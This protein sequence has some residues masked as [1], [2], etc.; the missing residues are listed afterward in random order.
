[1]R[2]QPSGLRVELDEAEALERPVELE[3]VPEDEGRRAGAGD[4]GVLPR[5]VVPGGERVVL[6]PQRGLADLRAD[7]LDGLGLHGVA[8]RVRQVERVH[9]LAAG[10]RDLGAPDG[11]PVLPEDASD[12]REQ[13]RAV[14]RPHLQLQALGG[15]PLDGSLQAPHQPLP[16]GLAPDGV[17]VDV[18]DVVL[19]VRAAAGLRADG[20]VVHHVLHVRDG[21]HGVEQQLGPVAAPDHHGRV[22]ALGARR[23]G[24]LRPRRA[25]GVGVGRGVPSPVV[26]H[27]L[28]QPPL[29][30]LRQA[31][32]AAAGA[33]VALPA[34]QVAQARADVGDAAGVL[35]GAAGL[36]VR[37]VHDGRDARVVRPQLGALDRAAHDGEHRA[38][39]GE[40]ARTVGARELDGGVLLRR[41]DSH[42]VARLRVVPV[43]RLQRLPARNPNSIRIRPGEIKIRSFKNTRN[44]VDEPA[45]GLPSGCRR[46]L[47]RQQP[48]CRHGR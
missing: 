20:A 3:Q 12:V 47:G 25:G 9:G 29:L 41:H 33:H 30:V 46:W 18:P 23:H 13:A 42:R 27:H 15:A 5:R 48:C 40:Q 1:L 31:A 32:R 28:V 44:S 11:E 2:N 35:D 19:L 24:H 21:A 17:P 34:Q 39:L 37:D 4:A 8:L 26:E 10:G 36:G 38:H 45:D 6:H 7:G 14:P 22:P 16:L 43:V